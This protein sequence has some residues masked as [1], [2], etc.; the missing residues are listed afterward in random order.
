VLIGANIFEA[1]LL[2]FLLDEHS[3]FSFLVPLNQLFERYVYEIV[4]ASFQRNTSVIYQ[5]PIK[6]L[7]S[8]DRNPIFELK[9]DISVVKNNDVLMIFDAK[10]KEITDT[11]SISQADIYQML[12]YS[13]KFRRNQITLVYPKFIGNLQ[14]KFELFRI[15]IPK[16]DEILT[17]RIIQI[18]IEN[19]NDPLITQFSKQFQVN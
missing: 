2:T 18:D 1:L 19:G 14:D 6:F 15:S 8:V 17:I 5:G 3:S 11:K 4:K 16:Y 12:A 7:G 13:V 10:Y 9:P